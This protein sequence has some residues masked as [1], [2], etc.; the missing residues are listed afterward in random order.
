MLLID[1]IDE[2]GILEA[3]KTVLTDIL[4]SKNVHIVTTSV[5]H[6]KCVLDFWTRIVSYPYFL[7]ALFFCTSCIKQ[8]VQSRALQPLHGTSDERCGHTRADACA[9]QGHSSL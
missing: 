6:C 1:G 7:A 4:A 2:C 3:A 9:P 8:A 5:L